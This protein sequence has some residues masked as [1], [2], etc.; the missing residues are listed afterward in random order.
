MVQVLKRDRLTIV[1][2]VLKGLDVEKLI[3]EILAQFA[4]RYY[5]LTSQ[6]PILRERIEGDSRWRNYLFTKLQPD[7]VSRDWSCLMDSG[8]TP[9]RSCERRS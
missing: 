8:P 1:C 9:Y 2:E 7:E 5:L 4:Y 6:G 3:E